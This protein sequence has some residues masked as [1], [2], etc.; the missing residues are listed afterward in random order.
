VKAPGFGD[1]RKAMLEDI[2]ALTGG[3]VISEDLGI[4]LENL[5]LD[6]LGRAKSVRIE[7]ENTTII[8]GAGAKGEPGSTGDVAVDGGRIAAAGGKAIETARLA[9]QARNAP[10]IERTEHSGRGLVL[11]L[12]D[13]MPLKN[14]VRTRL[15]AGGK[16][17]RTPGPTWANGTEITR[18]RQRCSRIRQ[19]TPIGF[20]WH[21]AVGERRC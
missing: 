5:T 13:G 3:Q 12:V 17:I 2:A 10:R 15:G 19:W 20:E 7:K 8:D 9:P 4:K 18:V 14:Q 16:R 11:G 21:E 6:M 1:R